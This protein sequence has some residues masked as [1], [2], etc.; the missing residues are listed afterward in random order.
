M[1]S[2][3]RLAGGVAHDF[4]NLLTVI[5][6]GVEA[7]KHDLQQGEPADPEIVDE[8]GAAGERARD[9][10]RQLLAFARRQVIDPM[11]L[12]LNILVRSSEKL[13]RRVLGEDIEL[14][15]KL[16]PDLWAVRCD[17]GQ[18]AGRP[19]PRRERTRRNAERRQAQHRDHQC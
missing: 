6:S 19:E 3:G 4:N 5:L 12:D 1:E 17:P 11:P 9:L 18:I 7:L 15:T 2:V 14:G 8:V 13:L 10:T 16:Q